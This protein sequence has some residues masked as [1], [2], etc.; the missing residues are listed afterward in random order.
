MKKPQP[1]R[2]HPGIA[3]VVFLVSLAFGVRAILRVT[4]GGDATSGRMVADAVDLDDGCAVDSVPR[5]VDLLALYGSYTKDRRVRSAFS[6]ALETAP[7]PMEEPATT[8]RLRWLGED[9]PMLE[10]GMVMVSA[11]ARRA[12]FG[13][14][15]VGI[16]DRIMECRVDSIDVGVVVCSWRGC[17]LTYELGQRA[18]CEFRAEMALRAASSSARSDGGSM[19]AAAGAES[20]ENAK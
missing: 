6:L 18:P 7:A 19:P 13:G 20:K 12:V 11:V 9:P 5:G 16:G 10:L 3:V 4:G 2:L 17:V 14:Q 8:T 1:K 15:V